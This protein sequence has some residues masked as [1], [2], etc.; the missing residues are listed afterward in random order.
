MVYFILSLKKLYW[1]CITLR[2][3]TTFQIWNFYFSQILTGIVEDQRVLTPFNLFFKSS[4][5]L[6]LFP[7]FSVY[8]NW[9]E[10]YV[11]AHLFKFCYQLILSWYYLVN[12]AEHEVII[13]Y[14]FE[15][16]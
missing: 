1:T 13:L 9:I 8:V 10:F 2:A 7:I 5:C 15:K 6:T 11:T 3:K 4:H 16:W 14:E 12:K